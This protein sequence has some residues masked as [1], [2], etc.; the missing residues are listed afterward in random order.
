MAM[1]TDH[2]VR[3]V[4]AD[5]QFASLAYYHKGSHTDLSGGVAMMI[6]VYLILAV[7]TQRCR[8]LFHDDR[9]NQLLLGGGYCYSYVPVRFN[10]EGIFQA[11]YYEEP[12]TSNCTPGLLLFCGS[13]EY[14]VHG[15]M[16][17]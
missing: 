3:P 1:N 8:L 10:D 14:F 12:I 6:H 2:V 7:V 13:L 11:E 5:Y 17:R 16:S 9:L 4:I 15:V